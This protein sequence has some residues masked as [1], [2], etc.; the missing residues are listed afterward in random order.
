MAAIVLS[1]ELEKVQIGSRVAVYKQEDDQYYEA[2][3]SR[4]RIDKKPLHLVYTNGNREWLDL[5]Q[6]SFILLEEQP[7]RRSRARLEQMEIEDT[8]DN[9]FVT[10]ESTKQSG[11]AHAR[12]SPGKVAEIGA[13]EAAQSSVAPR[14]LQPKK[15]GV[16]S[17]LNRNPNLYRKQT[18]MLMGRVQHKA[19]LG[20]DRRLLLG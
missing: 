6:H 18:T 10:Q 2:V 11:L 1:P 7:R 14:Y 12:V 9:T 4:E 19:Q 20:H 15:R 16:E 5:R 8:A 17:R 13:E 3:V